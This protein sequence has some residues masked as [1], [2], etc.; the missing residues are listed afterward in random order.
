[1]RQPTGI[2]CY[3]CVEADTPLAIC[4]D[5]D[6]KTEDF[7]N[8]HDR[9]TRESLLTTL[10]CAVRDYL[11]R[12]L[13][14]AVSVADCIFTESAFCKRKN[15][16]SYHMKITGIAFSRVAMVKLLITDMLLSA[17]EAIKKLVDENIYKVGCFRL[18]GSTKLGQ[19]RPLYPFA[20]QFEGQASKMPCDYASDYEYWLDSA[21]N[22]VD[23]YRLFTDLPSECG[24]TTSSVK[25]NVIKKLP[26]TV[27]DK[28]EVHHSI[29]S[30][31]EHV[32]VDM[33]IRAVKNTV[34][35]LLGI[36]PPKLVQEY[37]PWT[38]VL[39]ATSYLAEQCLQKGHRDKAE[40]I[41]NVVNDWSKGGSSYNPEH[42]EYH[43]RNAM[44]RNLPAKPT[45]IASLFY[46]AR[47]ANA[48]A[49]AAQFGCTG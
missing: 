29:C 21:I 40:A 35:K 24:I 39:F 23:G 6:M 11:K 4:F 44:T 42:F 32:M 49:T 34:S 27:S 26:A 47:K 36:L 25:A 5:V 48:A 30:S 19:Q 17:D 7:K 9:P 45:T 46:W 22:H 13:N 1:M 8:L 15:K 28:E 10:F 3:S 20:V 41:K 18:T 37:D 16:C 38:K 12:T 14:V 2:S 33:D 43:W 31:S